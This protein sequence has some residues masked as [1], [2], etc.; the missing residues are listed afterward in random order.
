MIPVKKES[1]EVFERREKGEKKD[2]SKRIPLIYEDLP[3]KGGYKLEFQN[4]EINVDESKYDWRTRTTNWQYNKEISLEVFEEEDFHPSQ[5]KF[6]VHFSLF[7]IDICSY[8]QHF[9][10]WVH[11][12]IKLGSILNCA[13]KQPIS[14]YFIGNLCYLLDETY[15]DKTLNDIIERFGCTIFEVRIKDWYGRHHF[16]RFRNIP[17]EQLKINK[18][19]VNNG[20][21]YEYI[22]LNK[23]NYEL[24]RYR[25]IKHPPLVNHKNILM[26]NIS[27]QT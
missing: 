4:L 17:F 26:K 27:T 9:T 15:F 18:V 10:V 20:S 5:K 6:K 25:S 23:K 12:S 1:K 19:L 13:L 16:K 24:V 7:Y 8:S 14:N 22:N 2:Q 21:K 3:V 11:P